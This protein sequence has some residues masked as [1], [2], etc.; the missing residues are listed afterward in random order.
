MTHYDGRWFGRGSTDACDQSWAMDINVRGG[1]VQGRFW[2]GGVLY[3]VFGR[4]DDEGVMRRARGGRNKREFGVISPRFL[5]FD[6]S[7]FGDVAE[8]TYAVAGSGGLF[9]QSPLELR[10][11]QQ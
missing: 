5:R 10:R 11:T 9:C 3:D 4:I 6:I 2:R 8:G 1:Q 7:F